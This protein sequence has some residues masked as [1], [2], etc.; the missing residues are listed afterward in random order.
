MAFVLALAA[1]ASAGEWDQYIDHNPQKPMAVA[2][3]EPAKPAAKPA[4][5]AKAPA[6]TAKATKPAKAAAKARP[7]TKARK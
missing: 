1:P 2:H 7:K 4:P 3:S 6:K 5:A